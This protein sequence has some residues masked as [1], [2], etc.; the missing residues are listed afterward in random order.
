[1]DIDIYVKTSVFPEPAICIKVPRS[2]PLLFAS[3]LVAN[4]SL[5]EKKSMTDIGSK[6]THASE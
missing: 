3:Q 4:P 1:M 5:P 2:S 6:A